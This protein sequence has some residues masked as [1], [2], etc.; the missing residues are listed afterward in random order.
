MSNNDG[1]HLSFFHS[2]PQGFPVVRDIDDHVSISLLLI[3]GRLSRVSIRKDGRT[4]DRGN[5]LD[6]GRTLLSLL[7]SIFWPNTN[8]N[9]KYCCIVLPDIISKTIYCP[10]FMDFLPKIY[11]RKSGSYLS[12][13]FW[14][15]FKIVLKQ[16]R[17]R[18]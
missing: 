18:S 9:K 10:V 5:I 11:L 16:V 12:L 2:R 14:T 7:F 4:L 3:V 13:L 17:E 6:G 8:K 15:S 1:Q